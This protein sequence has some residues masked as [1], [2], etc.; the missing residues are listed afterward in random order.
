M[1]FS[2]RIPFVAAVLL[3]A[4][5]W[6]AYAPYVGVGFK[7]DDFGWIAG[8]RVRQASDW[9]ALF[10]R[11]TGFYRPAVAVTF[12]LD[13]LAFGM[14]PL[15]YGLTNLALLL[16][17]LFAIAALARALGLAPGAALAA[18]AIWALNFQ[19]INMA[20]VWT[21][22]RTALL[23]V[24]FAALAANALVRRHLVRA[25]VFTLLAL[26]SKEEAV[27]LPVLLFVWAGML[28]GGRPQG[29]APAH[30]IQPE[31]D[32]GERGFTAAGAAR[33][34]WR[35][36]VRTA[37]PLAVPLAVYAVLRHFSGAFG[38]LSAPPYYRLTFAPRAVAENALKY[39]DFAA[40]FPAALVL[41]GA[42]LA[43]VVPRPSRWEVRI[44]ILGLAW[45][46]AGYAIT[47]FLPIRSPLYACFPAVGASLAAAALLGAVWSRSTAPARTRLAIA[48]LVL[49]FL[50]LPVY[51][52][53]NVRHAKGAR[54]SAQLLYDLKTASRDIPADAVVVLLD[55]PRLGP[56]ERLP[57]AFGTLY[58]IAVRDTLGRP[59]RS[60]IE[61][62]PDGWRLSGL[63]PP[64]P[65]AP[66]VVFALRNGR[67]V[68]Q[69]K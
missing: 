54:L 49:P 1:R 61:P 31:S 15:G 21:S 28:A 10:T 48:G 44:A 17:C 43:G 37:W 26:L 9:A 39:V 6:A 29:A 24:L 13:E 22:G 5:V 11:N 4:A 16:A 34:C 32:A 20:V 19:G 2:R 27:T 47:V 56:T 35:A 64:D 69:G 40:T 51:W 62:P 52:A 30:V 67:L 14:R 66:R 50:L 45:L 57:A 41:L 18:G 65:A 33:F 12:A 3:V 59:T 25:A 55:D 38:P 68:R 8:S 60:W 36:A 63:Q 23:L 42:A 46:V 58:D 7:Q 53:R